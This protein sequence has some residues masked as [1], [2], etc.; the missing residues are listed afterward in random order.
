MSAG[1]K[2]FTQA[3]LVLYLLNAYTKYQCPNQRAKSG[4]LEGRVNV[5]IKCHT[6]ENASAEVFATFHLC[7]NST[8]AV[9]YSS[10]IQTS[11]YMGLLAKAALFIGDL[12]G[13]MREWRGSPDHKPN[14]HLCV[15]H[16][17]PKQAIHSE[18]GDEEEETH[19]KSNGCN[20]IFRVEWEYLQTE[21]LGNPIWGFYLWAFWKWTVW[22]TGSNTAGSP[23]REMYLILVYL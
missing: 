14:S 23:K 17:Q 4:D 10:I 21:S 20:N 3:N 16:F 2:Y 8:W 6:V 1:Q 11:K 7:R 12:L 13:A 9:K 5:L 19:G 22:Q 15:S 18:E